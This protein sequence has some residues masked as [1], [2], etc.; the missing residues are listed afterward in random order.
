M[1][2]KQ[3]MFILLIGF[4]SQW[5]LAYLPIQH[6]QTSSGAQVYF[7]ENHDLPMLDISA[8]ILDIE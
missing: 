1:R 7:V 6:C 3:C 2:I 5:V 4:Y 8:G